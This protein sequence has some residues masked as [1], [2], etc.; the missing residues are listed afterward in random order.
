[1]FQKKY[2]PGRRLRLLGAGVSNLEPE[3]SGRQN[4]L[5]ETFHEKERNLEKDILEINTKYPHAALKRGRSWLLDNRSFI[6][7]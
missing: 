2:Q 5:F 7:H 6:K 3:S 4:E 1:L